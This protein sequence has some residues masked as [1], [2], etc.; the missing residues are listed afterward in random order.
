MGRATGSIELDDNLKWNTSPPTDSGF[1]WL[2]EKGMLPHIVRVNVD[3]DPRNKVKVI[4]PDDDMK[5]PVEM[6]T[7][8]L[9]SGPLKS[10]E[11]GA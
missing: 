6:W 9:W 3:L 4:L 11:R 2:K 7:G 5:Y 1:Y 10:P 8:A